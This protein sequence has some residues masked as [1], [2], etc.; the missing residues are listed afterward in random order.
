M[1]RN[2]KILL[3]LVAVA[4]AAYFIISRRP[5]ST[6]KPELKDFAIKDT[7]SITRFFLADKRGNSVLISKNEQGIWMVNNTFKADKGKVN[8]MLAT[9]HDVTVRNPISEK[10]F[11]NV[12]ATLAT[13]GVK[14][15]FYNG[16]D[17][18]KTIY[19][20]S[21]SADQAGT[22][23][24]I[25]GSSAP[26]VTHIEGFVGYLTPRFYAYPIKWKDKEVFNVPFEEVAKVKVEYPGDPTQS[27]EAT[28][29]AVPVVK[30]L[31]ANAAPVLSDPQFIK[32]Y[33]GSFTNLYFE[34]YDETMSGEKADSIKK[35]TPYCVVELTKKDGGVIKLQVNYKDVGDHSKIL[36]DENG[37]LLP[38]DTEK[39]F[40]FIN[41]D[42]DVVYIQQY[43]FG[44]IFKTLKDFTDK[45][46]VPLP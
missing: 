11:N 14:A 42:K 44:K 19:I 25:E 34:G 41:D 15:E 20:G 1:N 10:E 29:G 18:I 33:L 36:Y 24:L 2:L 27:F 21:A 43:N 22:F 32:Y 30:P 28:A 45:K 12:I 38:H 8:V 17:L 7:G 5:W 46:P 26:F 37:K 3:I 39:Y 13:N 31:I 23:M 9:M 4:A 16:G 35:M 6:I 40:G